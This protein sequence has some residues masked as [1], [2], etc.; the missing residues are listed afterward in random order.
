MPHS[1]G[2]GLKA[3]GF[4]EP[5]RELLGNVRG[6]AVAPESQN[7]DGMHQGALMNWSRGRSSQS[8]TS[9]PHHGI[10]KEKK[11]EEEVE[12]DVVPLQRRLGLQKGLRD[13]L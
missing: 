6:E 13:G 10:T 2:G 8:T 4:L 3:E 7:R 9:H 5:L 12:E 11:E 1:R